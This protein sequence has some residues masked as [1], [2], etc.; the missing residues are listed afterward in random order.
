MIPSTLKT[1]DLV[2]GGRAHQIG[3]RLSLRLTALGTGSGDMINGTT[4]L[5]GNSCFK[6]CQFNF[7]GGQTAWWISWISAIIVI[8]FVAENNSPLILI[9]DSSFIFLEEHHD[10]LK[11]GQMWPN[12][13]GQ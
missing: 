11:L 8:L 7:N 12:C 4:K 2:L 6:F 1:P 3:M 9:S 5:A 10:Q 13:R